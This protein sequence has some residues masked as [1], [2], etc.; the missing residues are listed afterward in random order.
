M[1]ATAHAYTSEGFVVAVDGRQRWGHEPSRDRLTA[2]LESDEVQKLFSVIDEQMTLAYSLKG[3]VANVDR[4]FDLAVELKRHLSFLKE[5]KFRNCLRFLEALAVSMEKS[6]AEALI[7]GRLDIYPTSYVCFVGYFKGE[8]SWFEL[9][10]HN[11]PDRDGRHWNIDKFD[12][13]PSLCVVS[14]SDAVKFAVE[15]QHELAEDF[16]THF[17]AQTSLAAASKFVEGYV[18]LC[19]TDW[20]REL[21]PSCI[22]IG[23]HVHTAT[24]TPPESR[25]NKFLRVLRRGACPQ[26]GFQWVITPLPQRESS[27]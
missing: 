24:I 1:T 3:D 20:A 21:D 2:R 18:R 7:Q 4:S 15:C 10:F 13:Q 25:W 26:T 5:K 27:I 22:K 11:S 17:G 23:G 14:G 16:N 9:Q 12:M 8:P 19:G 6:F